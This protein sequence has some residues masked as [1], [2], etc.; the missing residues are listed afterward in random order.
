MNKKII[1]LCM[2][3]K[4]EESCLERCLKSVESFADE[5]IIVDTGS[6]DKTKEIASKFTKN[7]YDFVWVDDFSK[8]RNFAFEKAQGKYVMWLDAD[9]Y[10]S[11]ENLEKLMA[12][13]NSIDVSV[14]VYMLKYEIA[15]DRSGNSTFTYYRERILKNDSSFVWQGA[16]HEV[17]T[18]HG[19]IEYTDIAIK[20]LKVNKDPSK[21]NLK[22][23]QKLLKQGKILSAREQ[24]YYSR[25]LFYNGQYKKAFTEAN[26]FLKMENVW[27]EDR[28]GAL[29]IKASCQLN[30]GRKDRA[31]LTLFQSFNFDAPRANFLCMIGDIYLT[32]NKFN[33]CIF[34]YKNALSSSK[35]YTNGGFINEEYYGVYP[36]LQLCLAYY[37]I[38]D[39]E[40]SKFYNDLALSLNPQNEIALKNEQFFKSIK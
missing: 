4:N 11:P 22:I 16:V 38:G 28:L 36:A 29:E 27:I 40:A 31:L 30:L 33:E 9:D 1:S 21:R 5:I 7:I 3:V 13:K 15:F 35:N 32:Q 34:W 10:I 39:M 6:T 24:Y 23:Y 14:D 37:K 17:I 25:E 2:I 20:H 19:K 12:L 26:R 18:P 8:A